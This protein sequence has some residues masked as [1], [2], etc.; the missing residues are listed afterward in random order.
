MRD[1]ER[2]AAWVLEDPPLIQRQKIALGVAA[3]FCL[4][5]TAVC[6]PMGGAGAQSLFKTDSAAA[7]WPF[8]FTTPILILVLC[9]RALYR[10]AKEKTALPNDYF[11]QI[12]KPKWPWPALWLKYA[13]FS[14]LGVIGSSINAYNTMQ[15]LPFWLAVICV[16]P[17]LL[18][19]GFVMVPALI[20]HHRQIWSL[21][22]WIFHDAA[23]REKQ[24]LTPSACL[25]TARRQYQ[26][27]SRPVRQK[28]NGIFEHPYTEEENKLNLL[29]NPLYKLTEQVIFTDKPKLAYA[30]GA[31]GFA[32]GTL[33]EMYAYPFSRQIAAPAGSAASVLFG[34]TVAY[35][36]MGICAIATSQVF[37]DVADDLHHYCYARESGLTLGQGIV[38]F[39]LL[40]LA[41]TSALPNVQNQIQM[42]GHEGFFGH[43][44]AISAIIAPACVFFW[45]GDLI[46]RDYQ[47]ATHG[48]S[49]MD[50]H[51]RLFRN[52]HSM[53]EVY[54]QAL[55]C[56]ENTLLV[57]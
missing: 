20:E 47:Y 42:M 12:R 17:A 55:P 5:S 30:V 38:R 51:D 37:S 9:G 1:S 19:P 41:L 23:W 22:Q 27:L 10:L 44:L 6:A 18:V 24:L 32:I 28:V 13:A 2:I 45:A 11:E 33:S 34:L 50:C 57:F 21:M 46:F 35:V 40:L 52:V 53:K 7:Y 3:V 16:G 43:V 48:L 36:R 8:F 56:S 31:L 29:F 49:Y 4:L 39:S 15:Y 26:Q 54:H 14:I 25:K